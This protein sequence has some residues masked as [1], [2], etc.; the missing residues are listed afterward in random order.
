MEIKRVLYWDVAKA[1]GMFLVVFGH[2]MFT[3]DSRGVNTPINQWIYSFHMAL[4]FIISGYFFDSS[5]QKDFKTLIM[6]KSLQLLVP[7]I[8][9]SVITFIINNLS[10]MSIEQVGEG[11]ICFVKTGGFFKGLW[12]LKALFVYYITGY[13]A[14]KLLRND[15]LAGLVCIVGIS[16]LPQYG[17]IYIFPVFFWIGFFLKKNSAWLD[18]K[19]MLSISILISVLSFV[20]WKSDYSYISQSMDPLSFCMRV[21]SGTSWSL[22]IIQLCKL[23]VPPPP[24][25]LIGSSIIDR[26]SL[27]G[28]SSLGIYAIHQALFMNTYCERLY[29]TVQNDNDFILFAYS[30]VVY[31]ASFGLTKLFMRQNALCKLLI[32]NTTG[33]IKSR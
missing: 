17:Y 32:G 28:A 1:V 27:I 8:S 15:L 20:C 4:F 24:K 3:Y 18:S 19:Y 26:I 14:I 13:I 5:L 7:V 31:L 25:K 21:I 10:S 33:A 6:S 16:L 30:V 12:F 11:I 9:W 29:R 22:V 2:L 23:S